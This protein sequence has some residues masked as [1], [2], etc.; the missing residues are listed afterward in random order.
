MEM[1]GHSHPSA[2]SRWELSERTLTTGKVP[3][4]GLLGNSVAGITE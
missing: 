4:G 1:F 3:L 2:D